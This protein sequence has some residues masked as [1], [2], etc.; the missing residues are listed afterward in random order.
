MKN[1][2]VFLLV[3]TACAT[4]QSV[5]VEDRS[6]FIDQ[7]YNTVLRAV[8]K[9]CNDKAFPILTVDKEL[10]IIN[11]DWKELSNVITGTARVRINF[12]LV[13]IENRVKIAANVQAQ[14]PTYGTGWVAMTMTESQAKDYY[15]M[16]FDGIRERL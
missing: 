5:R 16:I 10:G 13:S 11:T 6:T 2:I 8:I 3:L 12:M 9:Y 1:S 15:K 4:M 14:Q 7:E